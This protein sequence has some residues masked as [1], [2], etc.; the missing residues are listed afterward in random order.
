MKYANKIR[1]IFMFVLVCLVFS[2]HASRKQ[3]VT[4]IMVPRTKA[5]VRLG[6][7]ISNRYPTLF[8]SYLLGANG[9]VSLHGWTG[10]K[11][12]NITP[13]AFVAGSFFRKAPDSV[14]IVEKKNVP[15]PEKLIPAEEWGKNIS[16]ITT[17]QLRPLIHLAGQYFNFS[18]KEWAWFAEHYGMK[19]DAINPEG[20]NVKWYDK[21][22]VDHFGE[23][24]SFGTEDLQYWVVVRQAVAITP[25]AEPEVE[26][27]APEAEATAVE[28]EE[29]V[30]GNPFTNEVPAAVVFGAPDAPEEKK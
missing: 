4:L 21:R 26:V 30:V 25:V 22:L 27:A 14:L 18:Y 5:M 23:D 11:W 8:V 3:E 29:E 19:M 2:A 17:T 15:F 16:K 6:V 12:V 7:D 13:E 20:L 28:T 9:A 1:Q 24:N 10:S